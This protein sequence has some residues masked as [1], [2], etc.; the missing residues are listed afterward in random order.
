MAPEV[1]DRDPRPFKSDMYSLGLILHFML[2]KTLPTLSKNVRPGIFSIPLVYSKD[3]VD[4]MRK[5]LKEF[6]EQRPETLNSLLSLE[7]MIMASEKIQSCN[8]PSQD[9]DLKMLQ[10]KCESYEIEIKKLKA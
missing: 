10:K 7:Y 5:L 3:I 4:I 2:T 6:P 1:I 8:C 9:K